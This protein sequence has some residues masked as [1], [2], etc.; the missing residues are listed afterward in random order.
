MVH[1]P[2]LDFQL[3]TFERQA[4]YF[5]TPLAPYRLKVSMPEA[6]IIILLRDPVDR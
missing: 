6:K 5:A 1:P 2:T 3:L 4:S